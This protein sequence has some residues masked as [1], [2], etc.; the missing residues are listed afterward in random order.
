MPKLTCPEDHVRSNSTADS[1]QRK[2]RRSNPR[3]NK[4]KSVRRPLRE[5][6]GSP[7]CARSEANETKSEWRRLCANEMNSRL[8]A[9]KTDKLNSSFE[10]L[11]KDS[12][13]PGCIHSDTNRRT[14]RC[15]RLRRDEM[16]PR[17]EQLETKSGASLQQNPCN[18]KDTSE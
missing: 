5:N 4:K 6:N 11:R 7:N 8:V 2:P 18:G 10:K 12:G 1:D 15:A 17:V 9:S 14:S 16:E 13:D 3:S